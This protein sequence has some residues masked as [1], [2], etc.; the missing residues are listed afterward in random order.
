MIAYLCQGQA[1]TYFNSAIRVKI[2]ECFSPSLLSKMLS[3]WRKMWLFFC[4]RRIRLSWK[5]RSLYNVILAMW[6]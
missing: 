5:S 2:S 6:L 3:F 4:W 1:M